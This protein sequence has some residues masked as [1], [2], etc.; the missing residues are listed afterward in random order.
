MFPLKEV[1]DERILVHLFLRCLRGRLH[2]G[3]AGRERLTGTDAPVGEAK[4]FTVRYSIFLIRAPALE[5]DGQAKCFIINEPTLNIT[6]S[7]VG[8][9]ITASKNSV[10]LRFA[11]SPD[12]V[13]A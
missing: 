13:L 3:G 2:Q 1:L 8:L 5:N 4:L 7:V 11:H 10:H 12:D 6:Q 9:I